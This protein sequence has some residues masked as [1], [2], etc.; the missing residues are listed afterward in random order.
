MVDGEKVH[1]SQLSREEIDE[2]KDLWRNGKIAFE[3][4]PDGVESF[5][6]LG[7]RLI[8]GIYEPKVG[9]DKETGIKRMPAD[10]DDVVSPNWKPT[11]ARPLPSLRCMGVKENG[12]RCGR[13][14][15]R[16]GTLCPSHGSHL[17]GV[18]KSAQARVEAARMRLVGLSDDAVGVLEDLITNAGTNDAIRLK[19]A[20]EVLDRAGVKGGIDV[21]VEVE[22]KIDPGAA[23]A[24]RLLEISKR[25]GSKEP[26]IVLEAEV[27]EDD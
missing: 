4:L 14:A 23:I 3:E 19:A 27:V 22:H 24:E 15:I 11:V 13:W 21:T 6:T 17:P 25:A 5:D 26:E 1:V 9:R 8:L 16:G 7:R 18:K 2:L 10:F 12:Q 20:T